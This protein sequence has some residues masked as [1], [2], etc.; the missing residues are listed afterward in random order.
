VLIALLVRACRTGLS[1]RQ[2]RRPGYATKL[3]LV[4]SLAA[5]LHYIPM[6]VDYSDMWDVLAFFRGGING[7]GAHDAL[8]KEIAE[9][10]KEWVRLCYRW[11]DLEAYQYRSV[12]SI[13]S[14]CA[15]LLLLIG[16]AVRFESQT[17]T[18]VWS[19]LQ[20][21]DGAREQRL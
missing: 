4:P 16:V 19:A 9:A 21:C 1:V 12:S 11:A 5:W 17:A 3:T 15:C 20:R 8:G 14:P 18:R 6:Q 7:E 10:G 2:H 13:G